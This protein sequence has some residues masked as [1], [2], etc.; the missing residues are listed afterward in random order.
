[1]DM[2]VVSVS[3]IVQPRVERVRVRKPK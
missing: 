1:V 2:D 3:V